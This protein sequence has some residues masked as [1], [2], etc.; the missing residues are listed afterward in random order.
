[1]KW[2]P[3]PKLVHEIVEGPKAQSWPSPEAEV[4]TE[5]PEV[6][7]CWP[8]V[9]TVDPPLEEKWDS[10]Y[11]WVQEV[12][13]KGTGPGKGKGKGEGKGKGKGNGKGTGRGKGNE[14]WGVSKSWD[15]VEKFSPP[16]P[17]K[18]RNGPSN[19]LTASVSPPLVF[20]GLPVQPKVP[21]LMSV[22]GEKE[23]PFPTTG[24]RKVRV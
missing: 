11:T 9:E 10:Y 23:N 12:Q 24:P 2:A 16:T 7:V 22:D 14:E 5:F 21:P 13:V 19:T 18:V 20:H 15:K 1:M 3:K 6:N 8:N 17:S 4:P